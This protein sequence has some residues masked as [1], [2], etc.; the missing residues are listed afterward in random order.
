MEKEEER[1]EKKARRRRRVLSLSD[2]LPSSTH[3][4]VQLDAVVEAQDAELVVGW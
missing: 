2:L 3:H 4:I 1:V